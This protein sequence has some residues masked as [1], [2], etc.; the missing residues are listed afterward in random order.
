MPDPP[1][2][3]LWFAACQAV[4][5][6]ALL[7]RGL[8]CRVG[9]TA[10]AV[11]FG[12]GWF[13]LR[14]QQL[15]ADSLLRLIPSNPTPQGALVTVEG[16]VQD[17]PSPAP[18]ARGALGRFSPVG[19]TTKFTFGTSGLSAPGGGGDTPCSGELSVSVRSPA[20]GIEPGQWLRLTGHFRPL[21]PPA[22]PGEPD[23]RESGAQDHHVGRLAVP[24]EALIEPLGPDDSLS[25]GAASAWASLLGALRARAGDS[26]DA[27]VAPVPAPSSPR[28]GADHSTRARGRA[29]LAAL[30]LG[31]RE[32]ALDDVGPAFT[33]LGLVHLIA[34]SGFNLAVMATVALFLIRFLGESRASGWLEPAIVASLVVVYMLIVPAEAPVVRSG[35]MVL[36]FLAAEASGRRYD[37]LTLLGWIAVTL[38]LWRPMDLWSIGFQLSFGIVAVLLWLGPSVQDRLFGVPLRGTIQPHADSMVRAAGRAGANYLKSLTSSSLLAWAV[39]AP[40]VACQ[41]GLVSPLAPLTT[42]IVLPITV[43][44]LWA[45]YIALGL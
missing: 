43:G 30:L 1:S 18:P 4:L 20:A 8:A 28:H 25:G 22:N 11:L 3:V 37:R 41:I 40:T 38:L 19:E 7:R 45:G 2:P 44:V 12:A 26:L 13:D 6:P 42:I 16:I 34:I 23:R 24:S 15:P 5:I 39:A 9:L 14:V 17:R 29:L 33:R 32:P 27:A 36:A 21:E 35:L 10:A 31:Q